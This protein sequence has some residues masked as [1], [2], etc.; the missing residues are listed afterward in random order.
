MFSRAERTYLKTL[1]EG[2]EETARQNLEALF[3]NP[4]YRRKLL[5]GIRQK[6]S[7]SFTDWQLYAEAARRDTRIVPRRSSTDS[8]HPPLFTDP[9]ITALGDFRRLLARRRRDESARPHLPGGPG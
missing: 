3:P 5:W 1:V 9:L 7:R 2:S 6:A 4:V 8:E